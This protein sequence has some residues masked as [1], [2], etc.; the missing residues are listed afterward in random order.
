MSVGKIKKIDPVHL[1]VHGIVELCFDP[2]HSQ[3]F[4]WTT[5]KPVI[6]TLHLCRWTAVVPFT[7]S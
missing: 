7:S 2:L 4:L 6:S 5:I 3:T 1:V